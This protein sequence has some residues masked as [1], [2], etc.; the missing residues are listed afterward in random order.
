M[1]GYYIH[2]A[3]CDEETLKNRSFVLGVEAPDILKKHLK[4]Y[5]G[6]KG[7]RSK[8]ETLRT[9]DMPDYHELEIRIQQKERHGS[10]DGLHYG[11]SS[12]PDVKAFWNA[13]SEEQKNNPFYKGYA[14]HLLT[15]AILYA[16][17]NID[18]K[19]EKFLEANQRNPNIEE[20]RKN[21]V[22]KLHL[23]WDK[24][25]ACIRDTYV[26]VFLP[27]EIQELA[28]VQFVSDGE[29]VYVDWNVV[30]N[31]INYMRTFDPLNGKMDEIIE[32]VMS[33]I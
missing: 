3:T 6:V 15:D 26:G 20:L 9:V 21:E 8:Y 7:A 14:W 19:F 27:D 16:R 10:S 22:K 30:E 29:L 11:P 18:A 4:V 17:L 5:G 24:T 2:L 13:L 28:I 33:N 31:T 23:D 32:T 12:S 1:P 25:N